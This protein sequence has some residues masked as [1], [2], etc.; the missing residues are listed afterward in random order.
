MKRLLIAVFVLGLILAFTGAAFSKND[1]GRFP[2]TEKRPVTEVNLQPANSH[3]Q[4]YPWTE[5]P[6]ANHR[7]VPIP[8]SAPG[9]EQGIASPD[10]LIPCGDDNPL[11]SPGRY[12][13]VSMAGDW[14]DRMA[15]SYAVQSGH[16]INISAIKVRCYK[17]IGSPTMTLQIHKDNMGN[18]GPIVYTQ[19]YALTPLAYPGGT[20]T[21][22]LTTPQTIAS[23]GEP[24]WVSVG[25]TGLPGDTVGVGINQYPDSTAD[26]RGRYS[27]DGTNYLTFTGAGFSMDWDPRITVTRCS[28][29]TSCYTGMKDPRGMYGVLLPDGPFSDGSNVIGYAQRFVAS[30]PET[31]S[32]VKVMTVDYTGSGGAPAH[33][34]YGPSS[35]N[36][37]I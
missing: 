11:H 19:N 36:G 24:V 30:G 4:V 6:A 18:P 35:T 15:C 33:W 23:S 28:W 3:V 1:D 20:K 27:L 34:F 29:Y 16:L 8:Q 9:F 10:T 31:L 13:Y 7:A 17:I 14:T 22:A 5:R 2:I 37:L 25:F 26:G 12:T 32:A 21:I